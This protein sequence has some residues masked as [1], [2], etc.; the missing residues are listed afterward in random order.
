MQ[1][2]EKE[3][4]IVVSKEVEE[5]HSWQHHYAL[6]PE[7][8][9]PTNLS[10]NKPNHCD[11]EKKKEDDIATI[12]SEACEEDNEKHKKESNDDE[13]ITNR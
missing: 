6:K 12:D 8:P 5:K 2:K 11:Q 7:L 9:Y 10:N 3:L 1:C 13:T 4:F